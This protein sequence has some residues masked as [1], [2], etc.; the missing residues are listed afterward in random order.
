MSQ[1]VLA[2]PFLHFME[3]FRFIMVR[4]PQGIVPNSLILEFVDRIIWH[5]LQENE[6]DYSYIVLRAVF[7]SMGTSQEQEQR[8]IQHAGWANTMPFQHENVILSHA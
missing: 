7:E 8:L 3:R 2:G 1:Q 6:Q 5:A 4:R